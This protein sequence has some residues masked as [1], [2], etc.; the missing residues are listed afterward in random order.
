M[1]TNFSYQVFHFLLSKNTCISNSFRIIA[2]KQS[3]TTKIRNNLIKSSFNSMASLVK[4]GNFEW[5][6]TSNWSLRRYNCDGSPFPGLRLV[7][8][9]WFTA[10]VVV[11]G[12]LLHLLLERSQTCPPVL[13]TFHFFEA[14]SKNKQFQAYGTR[15]DYNQVLNE[16]KKETNQQTT[17]AIYHH[18]SVR[19]KTT[20]KTGF[21]KN[22]CS[23]SILL[24]R[25][26]F[27]EVSNISK[28]SDVL[29][30]KS[31]NKTHFKCKILTVYKNEGS[32]VKPF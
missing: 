21:S 28:L 17:Y 29:H 8:Y 24:Y 11:F 22:T 5:N 32:S 18:F 19:N 31:W 7:S 4:H 12:W 20:E 2:L 3:K 23:D 6:Y 14:E 25:Y 16:R 10:T 15:W 1:S 9:F 27:N 13:A 26:N 30:K